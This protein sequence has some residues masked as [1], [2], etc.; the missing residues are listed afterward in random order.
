MALGESEP[1]GAAAGSPGAGHDVLSGIIGGDRL[2]GVSDKLDAK[3]ERLGSTLLIADGGA[4]APIT[5]DFYVGEDGHTH[6]VVGWIAPDG[7]W[8]IG[9]DTVIPIPVVK[10]VS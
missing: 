8:E 1:G 9:S 2:A 6:V 10:P 7:T 3:I 5:V 4:P